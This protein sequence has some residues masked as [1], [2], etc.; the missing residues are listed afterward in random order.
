MDVRADNIAKRQSDYVPVE[1]SKRI[2]VNKAVTVAQRQSKYVAK[3]ISNPGPVSEPNSTANHKPEYSTQHQ[4]KHEAKH[5]TLDVAIWE[6]KCVAVRIPDD[7][8]V[9]IAYTTSICEPHRDS[10]E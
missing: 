8:A 9:R 2:A 4:A 7:S 3:Y 1:L 6:S 10:I 5:V